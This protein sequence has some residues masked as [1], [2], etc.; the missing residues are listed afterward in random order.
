MRKGY[1]TVFILLVC[2]LILATPVLAERKANALDRVPALNVV[3]G[4][5]VLVPEVAVKTSP[6]LE[7]ADIVVELDRGAFFI[8]LEEDAE[9]DP[10]EFASEL[11]K[12]LGTDVEIVSTEPFLWVVLDE[13][14]TR[15][16]VY[17]ALQEI[18]E[19]LDWMVGRSVG[20]GT[21][22]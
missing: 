5:A 19:M 16:Q 21:Y 12:A 9:I 4:A 20:W 10:K 18:E 1:M 7:P 2:G 17:A 13:D 15:E 3:S 8:L 14:A 11:G 22:W 6:A